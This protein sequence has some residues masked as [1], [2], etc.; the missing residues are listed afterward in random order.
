MI[1]LPNADG[2][3]YVAV[4]GAEHPY[5][6]TQVG[7][8]SISE[9]ILNPQFVADH[10]EFVHDVSV[11]GTI[12]IVGGDA[13]VETYTKL[14]FVVHTKNGESRVLVFA[15]K[16]QAEE[17][18]LHGTVDPALEGT[19]MTVHWKRIVHGTLRASPLITYNDAS[20]DVNVVEQ[21]ATWN[22]ASAFAAQASI[23]LPD[24]NY[25]VS[26][27]PTEWFISHLHVENGPVTPPNILADVADLSATSFVVHVN[28]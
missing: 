13:I 21:H 23:T 6:L 27:A 24:Q 28:L 18:E 10:P 26:G 1:D 16:E 11:T 22:L 12:N 20:T 2:Y 17:L 4:E 19:T 14:M 15:Y 7:L 3:T 5:Q 25:T 9:P 8:G